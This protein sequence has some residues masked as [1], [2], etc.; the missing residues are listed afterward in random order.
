MAVAHF[1][2]FTNYRASFSPH[3]TECIPSEKCLLEFQP[4]VSAL[5]WKCEC[6]EWTAP[7]KWSFYSSRIKL[8]LLLGLRY[9]FFFVRVMNSAVAVE[10]WA[11]LP[12]PPLFSPF[13]WNVALYEMDFFCLIWQECL[14]LDSQAWCKPPK[15]FVPVP[16]KPNHI[17]ASEC[18]CTQVYGETFKQQ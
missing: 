6:S 4:G 10:R 14:W 15:P 18:L 16:S 8:A 1:C 11:C 17:L 13:C 12:F 3:P 9:F 7:M 2:I 5:Q